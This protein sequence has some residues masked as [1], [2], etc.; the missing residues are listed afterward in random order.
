MSNRLE[1]LRQGLSAQLD[2]WL[3]FDI[4]EEG[5]DDYD[6]WRWRQQMIREVQTVADVKEYLE[7]IG[8]DDEAIA[9]FLGNK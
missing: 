9:E 1:N 6:T 2:E 3:G 5:D 4:P 7:I 8:M